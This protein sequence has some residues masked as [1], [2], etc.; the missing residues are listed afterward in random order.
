MILNEIKDVLSTFD[1]N[2]YYGSNAKH[3]EDSPWDYIVFGRERLRASGNKTGLADV[4]DVLI[5]REEFIEDGLPERVIDALV[6]IPGIRV[7][8]EDGE[9]TYA[10]NPGTKDTVEMLTLRFVRARKS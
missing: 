10:V 7:S 6:A 4:F 2:V 1:E 3:D 9:Y 8:S 5:S